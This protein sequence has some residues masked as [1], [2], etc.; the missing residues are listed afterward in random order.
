MPCHD[1]RLAEVV[2]W[3]GESDLERLT[4]VW[5]HDR[6]NRG[7]EAGTCP[8]VDRAPAGGSRRDFRSRRAQAR[9]TKQMMGS[10]EERVHVRLFEAKATDCGFPVSQIPV[11]TRQ[12]KQIDCVRFP[13]RGN[14]FA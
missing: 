13:D 14:D 7:I 2:S 3:D 11:R 10:A 12:R 9:V 1:N 5:K 4:S 6:L 8:W